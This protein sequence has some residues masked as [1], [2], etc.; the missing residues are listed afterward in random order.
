MEPSQPATPAIRRTPIREAIL[1]GFSVCVAIF[2]CGPICAIDNVTFKQD[3]K[4]IHAVGKAIVSAQDGG[5][6]ILAPDG[7]MWPI[8]PE[9][10]VQRQSDD[11]PYA[12]YST[13]ELKKHVLAELPD[14]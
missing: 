5:L 6:M 14:G 12:A 13:D 7:Q 8:L 4:T 3:G 10:L 11:Q 2:C 9:E 1:I